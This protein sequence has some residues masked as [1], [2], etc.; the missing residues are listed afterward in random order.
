MMRLYKFFYSLIIPF[1]R[2]LYRVR[3]TGRENIPEG[4]AVVC[5]NHTSMTDPFF[6]AMAF[7]LREQLVFLGKIEVF[8]MPVIGAVLRGIQ[9]IPVD[10]GST[11]MSTLREAISRLK[12]GRKVM[13]FPEGTRVKANADA[14]GAKTGAAMM[15]CRADAPMLPVYISVKRKLFGRVDV[16]IGKPVDTHSFEGTGSAKYKAVVEN[17]FCEILSLGNGGE[18]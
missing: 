7:G 6:V 11:S 8:R 15:A 5:A 17:V 13:I 1:F 14:S 12:E 18:S 10:R 4:S 9:A 3:I 2:I 16:I